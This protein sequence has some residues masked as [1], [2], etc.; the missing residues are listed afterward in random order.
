MSEEDSVLE[1]IGQ[2]IT[3]TL[4]MLMLGKEVGSII[5]KKGETIK[6]IREQSSARVSISEG[7]SPSRITTITGPTDAVFEAV[8]MITFKLAE[9]ISHVNDNG[10]ES[11][12]PSATL[13]LVVRSSQCGSIIGK[14][15]SRIKEIR[16]ST[17]AQVQVAGEMLPNST[18][19]TVTLTGTPEAVIESVKQISFVILE[20]S[21]KGPSI[22][23]CP[24]MSLGMALLSANQGFPVHGQ[25]PVTHAEVNKLQQYSLHQNPFSALPQVP[26]MISALETSAPT[27]SQEFLIP[28]DCIGC[29]IGRQGSKIRE[30]R[31]MSGALIR[32]GSQEEG[33]TERLVTITGTANSITVAQYLIT[34]CLE[35]ARSSAQAASSSSPSEVGMSFSQAPSLPQAITMPTMAGHSPSFLTTPYTFPLSNFLGIKPYPLLAMAPSTISPAAGG[36]SSYMAKICAANGTKKAERQ[37]FSPY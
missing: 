25:F 27:T 34:A 22:P 29:V 24:N 6:G 7:P 18:E 15:G 14:A 20:T 32:I 11:V 10:T 8:S 23:Y 13:R 36:L 1:D 12:T 2:K 4:R 21:P 17:G 31:Q 28:N 35:T 37:K 33:S 5:G 19:R 9:D 16:E 3:L 30:I 26:A